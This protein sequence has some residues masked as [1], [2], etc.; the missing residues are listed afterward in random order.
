MSNKNYDDETLM[1]KL[2][3]MFPF[4]EFYDI[5]FIPVSISSRLSEEFQYILANTMERNNFIV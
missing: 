1:M 5:R 4:Q 3:R 2:E